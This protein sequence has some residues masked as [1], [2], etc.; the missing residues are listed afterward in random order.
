MLQYNVFF[1][2]LFT[3]LFLGRVDAFD[4]T[5]EQIADDEACDNDGESDGDMWS[6]PAD[7]FPH[8][9]FA[10]SEWLM[11]STELMAQFIALY[12]V[13]EPIDAA[14]VR[15]QKTASQ[16][17][18]SKTECLFSPLFAAATIVT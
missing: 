9:L 10:I 6:E 18:T 17:K 16:K 8:C 1:S 2:V 3:A 15:R 7:H 13:S 4:D 12:Q 11:E 5:Y 14:Y